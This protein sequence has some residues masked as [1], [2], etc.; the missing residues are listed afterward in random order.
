MKWC[1]Q[2]EVLD[3][4]A[5]I[6]HIFCAEDTVPHKPGSGEVGCSSQEF[7]WIFD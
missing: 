7:A 1:I 4:Q 2:T 5:H 3:I 6:P